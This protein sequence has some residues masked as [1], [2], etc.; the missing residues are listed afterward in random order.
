MEED[1]RPTS[2]HRGGLGLA[3]HFLEPNGEDG[4]PG[5][6]GSGG[7]NNL[8]GGGQNGGPGAKG[9]NAAG[10]SPITNYGIG[11]QGSHDTRPVA[12]R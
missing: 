1:L 4:R 2:S 5:T 12:R 8:S 6:P 3:E 10:G 9:T 7:V 11:Q